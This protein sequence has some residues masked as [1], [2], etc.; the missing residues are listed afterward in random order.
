MFKGPPVLPFSLMNKLSC[1]D[2]VLFILLISFAELQSEKEELRKKYIHVMQILES[3]KT[4]KWQ[5]LQ[6]CEE[7]G[8]LVSSLKAEVNFI[9]IFYCTKFSFLFLM[10]LR[11]EKV[12][13]KLF[14]LSWISELQL[15]I[16]RDLEAKTSP[17]DTLGWEH[18]LT[19]FEGMKWKSRFEF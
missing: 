19:D 1:T 11:C 2:S 5:L 8:Q 3:E 7:Q 10:A 17:R 18:D 15:G 13:K 9:F 12:A 6:Q 14:P 16:Q 4:A